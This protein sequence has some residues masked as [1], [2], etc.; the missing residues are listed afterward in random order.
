MQVKMTNMI[1]QR[2]EVL[3]RFDW[4]TNYRIMFRRETARSLKK[5]NEK[6]PDGVQPVD[7]LLPL[8]HWFR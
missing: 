7:D 1:L 8:V 4:N 3:C 5:K 2:S 6:L